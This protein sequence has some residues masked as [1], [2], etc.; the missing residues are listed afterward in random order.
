VLRSTEVRPAGNAPKFL[1]WALAF[2]FLCTGVAKLLGLPPTQQAFEHLAFPEHFALVVGVLEIAGAIGL[3]IP[4]LKFKAAVGLCGIM[5]GAVVTH[6][7]Y[8][9]IYMAIRAL[10][11]LALLTGIAWIHRPG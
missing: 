10:V 9:P 4:G 2:L 11:V 6:L 3:L 5:I 7:T 1:C 8:D